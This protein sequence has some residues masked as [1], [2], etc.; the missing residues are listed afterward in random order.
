MVQKCPNKKCISNIINS[1][2]SSTIDLIEIIMVGKYMYFFCVLIAFIYFIQ[3]G[4]EHILIKSPVS[5]KSAPRR[6]LRT[7]GNSSNLTLSTF[8]CISRLIG[9]TQFLNLKKYVCP[10]SMI[11]ELWHALCTTSNCIQFS[12]YFHTAGSWL[13]ILD[14]PKTQTNI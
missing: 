13:L 8:L 5:Y 3:N 12:S 10:N 1:H 11:C 4:W 14:R 2:I 9:R 6:S 7:F